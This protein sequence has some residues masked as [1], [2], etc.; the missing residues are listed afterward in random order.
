M[1]AIIMIIIKARTH[2]HK[3]GIVLRYGTTA[4]KSRCKK[5]EENRRRITIINDNRE[6]ERARDL[7]I[8]TMKKLKK[9]TNARALKHG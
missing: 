6:T 9:K 5:K 8:W 2:P 4:R 3:Q 7:L 1:L